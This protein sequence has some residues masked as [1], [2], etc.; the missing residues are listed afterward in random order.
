MDD[1]IDLKGNF[2]FRLWT[3]RNVRISTSKSGHP[4][5]KG[6]LKKGFPTPKLRQRCLWFFHW[7]KNRCTQNCPTHLHSIGKPWD[8]WGFSLFDSFRSDF[9]LSQTTVPPLKTII[10]VNTLAAVAASKFENLVILVLSSRLWLHCRQLGSYSIRLVKWAS[11]RSRSRR[12]FRPAIFPWWTR[13]SGECINI[14]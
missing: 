7:K 5:E 9:H 6:W 10:A 8:S 13:L 11:R 12:L 14:K 2:T 3:G 4:A 1:I